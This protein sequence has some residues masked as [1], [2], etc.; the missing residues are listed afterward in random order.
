MGVNMQNEKGNY[1][2]TRNRE[3]FLVVIITDKCKFNITEV[4]TRPVPVA[5]RS[6][7]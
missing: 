7:A 6:K 4:Y 1:F 2:N 3:H 5:A